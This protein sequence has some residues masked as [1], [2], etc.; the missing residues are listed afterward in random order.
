[1]WLRKPEAEMQ[2]QPMRRK[3]NTASCLWVVF[4]PTWGWIQP[5]DCVF[6]THVL[7]HCICSSETYQDQQ[8][9]PWTKE[10]KTSRT[11][12]R[13]KQEQT[14]VALHC[15]HLYLFT[16]FVPTFL[17]NRDSNHAPFL[18]FHSHSSPLREVRW[19]CML[20]LKSLSKLPW[21]NVEHSP[22]PFTGHFSTL[23]GRWLPNL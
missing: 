2:L 7:M 11:E 8:M 22:N 23:G 6:D 4:H 3:K 17:P 19:E 20:G 13:G 16:S 10:R 5:M 18:H 15:P 12:Q 9:P 14:L 21:Q 1:M